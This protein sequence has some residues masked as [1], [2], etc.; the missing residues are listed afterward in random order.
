MATFF[1]DLKQHFS[2]GNALKRLIIVNAVLFVSISLLEV[3]GQL[4]QIKGLAF[5]PYLS[6]SSLPSG[7]LAQPWAILTYMFMHHDI[8]H[9]VFNMLWLYWFGALFMQLF[10]Q[11]QLVALYIY[12]GIAGALLYVVVYNT[13][14][15]FA[16]KVSTMVGASASVL[17]IVCATAVRTPDYTMRFLFIGDVKLKYIAI[18]TIIF[19]LLGVTSDNAGGHWAHLGGAAMGCV[20]VLLLK[21]G[22]D[23]TKGFNLFLDKIMNLARPKPKMKVT[24]KR[25]ESDNDFKVRK[26]QDHTQLD[27][28]LDKLKR[29]GYGSLNPEE[30]KFLFDASKK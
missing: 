14:P 22:I 28:I 3:I 29:S 24:Y 21:N 16:G 9:I 18:A 12:G 6:I 1:T 17:A 19:D 4:F 30:K 20:F 15:F 8:W 13:F 25:A 23:I 2:Q 5:T 26:N 7:L 10:T 11:K 27:A